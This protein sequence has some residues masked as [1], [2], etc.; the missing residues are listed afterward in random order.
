ML[1]ASMSLERISLPC[2]F[3]IKKWKG[4]FVSLTCSSKVNCCL[5]LLLLLL[6]LIWGLLWKFADAAVWCSNTLLLLF[7]K[8]NGC[9]AFKFCIFLGWTEP[10]RGFVAFVCQQLVADCSVG[11]LNTWWNKVYASS[12]CSIVTSN[13]LQRVLWEPRKCSKTRTIFSKLGFRSQWQKIFKFVPRSASAFFSRFECR[14]L[15]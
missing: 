15:E 2:V 13:V 3:F 8:E 5:L 14:L 6:E 12:H 4:S 9:A 1:N 11:G 7:G 10:F